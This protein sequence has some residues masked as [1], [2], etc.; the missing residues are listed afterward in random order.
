MVARIG[1]D[2]GHHVA[3]AGL[4]H[5]TELLPR[6]G[7]QMLVPSKAG[8]PGVDPTVTVCRMLPAPSDYHAAGCDPVPRD[9]PWCRSSR[10]SV[11]R[12]TGAV[13]LRELPLRF[14]RRRW[15]VSSEATLANDNARNV[16]PDLPRMSATGRGQ[17]RLSSA[18]DGPVAG[19]CPFR[20]GS[21]FGGR[22]CLCSARTGG[23]R[24][25]SQADLALE[26][27]PGWAY[28]SAGS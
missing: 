18:V 22:G 24:I 12:L 14:L 11:E 17:R 21:M 26:F 5:S 15:Q 10:T 13:N 19:G 3:A 16:R 7:T 6:F 27:D 20:G 1:A 9:R 28:P 4:D 8:Y 23:S 25:S 2:G